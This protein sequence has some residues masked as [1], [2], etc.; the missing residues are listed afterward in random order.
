MLTTTVI[1]NEI[2]AWSCRSRLSHLPLHPF[3]RP[4][5][6]H[7]CRVVQVPSAP[8]ATRKRITSGTN[9]T[10]TIYTRMTDALMYMTVEA[11]HEVVAQEY[12]EA[13]GYMSYKQT[14]SING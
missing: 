12:V 14:T 4:R 11:M 2:S 6:L 9:H 1:L 5:S 8:E 3:I 13:F 7:P 10:E